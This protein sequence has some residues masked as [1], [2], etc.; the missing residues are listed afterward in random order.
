MAPGM[1]VIRRRWPVLLLA[2]L[3]VAS[4]AGAEMLLPPGFTAQVYLTGEGFDPGLA[5]GNPGVPAVGTIAVDRTG[6]VYLARTGRRYFGGEVDDLWPIYRV[7]PGGG[8]MTRESE[9]R[10]LHGPPLPSPQVAARTR[11]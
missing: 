7:A 11:M 9:G 3:A 6:A 10:Y 5:R 8:R 4:P 1:I 2:V